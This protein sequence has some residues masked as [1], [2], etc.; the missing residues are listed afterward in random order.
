MKLKLLKS[1]FTLYSLLMKMSDNK[2]IRN[3]LTNQ[4]RRLTLKDYD[5]MEGM[6]LDD[7]EWV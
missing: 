6:D 7:E 1:S 5:A 2:K 4:V 3:Y